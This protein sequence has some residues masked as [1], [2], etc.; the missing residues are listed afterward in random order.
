L[1][2]VGRPKSR[3]TRK[4]RAR[5]SVGKTGGTAQRRR[6]RRLVADMVRHDPAIRSV[7]ISLYSAASMKKRAKTLRRKRR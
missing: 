6:A 5:I 4:K 7:S 2:R 1:A 3:A